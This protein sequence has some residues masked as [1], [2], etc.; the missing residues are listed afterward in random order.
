MYE[1]KIQNKNIIYG[2]L[3]T[4]LKSE[5]NSEHQVPLGMK[6]NW[7]CKKNISSLKYLLQILAI[8]FNLV[9]LS[10]WTL[11]TVLIYACNVS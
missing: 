7:G 8:Y 5:E 11:L 10:G 9:V 1:D 2:Y 3:V 4:V 6:S